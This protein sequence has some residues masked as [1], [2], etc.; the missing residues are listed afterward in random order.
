MKMSRAGQV[1]ARPR[2]EVARWRAG[3]AGPDR[4]V[5]RLAADLATAGQR[6]FA[7]RHG[8]PEGPGGGGGEPDPARR[9]G[10]AVAGVAGGI[11]ALDAGG[12]QGA[13]SG[14]LVLHLQA[15]RESL[16]SR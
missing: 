3:G 16:G 8:F 12:G 10:G 6:N 11:E 13:Q 15:G 7:G 14:R 4:C 1:W 2:P 9:A 5:R